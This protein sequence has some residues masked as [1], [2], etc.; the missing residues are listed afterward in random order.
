MPLDLAQ[1]KICSTIVLRLS[2]IL[3]QQSKQAIAVVLSERMQIREPASQTQ[4]EDGGQALRQ[5]VT[6]LLLTMEMACELLESFSEGHISNRITLRLTS[7]EHVKIIQWVR[8]GPLRRTV[9]SCNGLI[10]Q[11]GDVMETTKV[12]I[13]SR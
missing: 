7:K 9:R 11:R 3:P 6:Q 13:V 1:A 8:H 4:V 2:L 12:G 10:L 5:R